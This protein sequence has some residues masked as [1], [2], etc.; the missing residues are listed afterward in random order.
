MIRSTPQQG[1]NSGT[2][3]AQN[4]RAYLERIERLTEE[5][6]SLADDIADIFK[7]L[8]GEGYDKHAAKIV[9]KIRQSAEGLSTY[10]DRTSTVDTYLAALGMLPDRAGARAHGNIEE[11]PA[12]KAPDERD[13]PSTGRVSPVGHAD[14]GGDGANAGGNDEK[15]T[16]ELISQNSDLIEENVTQRADAVALGSTVEIGAQEFEP[17]AFLRQ[18]KPFRPHCQNRELCAGYGRKHCHTCLVAAGVT[19]AAA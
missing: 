8:E 11:F 3:A 2:P 10:T 12:S 19:E 4:L 5:R 13:G 17:P 1:H 16:P 9:L 15:L 6:K 14:D 18:D 7:E